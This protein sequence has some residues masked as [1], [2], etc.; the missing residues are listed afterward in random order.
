[1][2]IKDRIIELV[3]K[4]NTKE[5][6]Q[7]L[8]KIAPSHEFFDTTVSLSYRFGDIEKQ[9]IKGVVT[10]DDQ[11][12][13]GNKVV[14]SLTA[15][16]RTL[17]TP[18]EVLK[19]RLEIS[20]WSESID[21]QEV[22]SFLF[23]VLKPNHHFQVEI[24]LRSL[25]EHLDLSSNL[26]QAEENNRLVNNSVR[27]RLSAFIEVLMLDELVNDWQDSFWHYC[28]NNR[29]F[30]V[31]DKQKFD[32]NFEA[33]KYFADL[34][35][36]ENKQAIQ[37]LLLWQEEFLVGNYETSLKYIDNVRLNLNTDSSKAY[38]YLLLTHCNLKLDDAVKKYITKQDKSPLNRIFIYIERVQKF[39]D[40]SSTRRESLNFAYNKI[41][42]AIQKIYHNISFDYILNKST[43]GISKKRELIK[44]TI[45][46]SILFFGKIKNE[47]TEHHQIYEDLIIELI[48]GGKYTWLE[49]RYDKIENSSTFGAVERL[50]QLE[51]VLKQNDMSIVGLKD[52]LY[53]EL[54]VKAKNIDKAIDIKKATE[55]LTKSCYLAFKI[56]ND[57]KF[58]ELIKSFNKPTK[59]Q[60]F[61]PKAV[62]HKQ[63]V[64]I[65]NNQKQELVVDESY[66]EAIT[67][68]FDLNKNYDEIFMINIE[69]ITVHF[70]FFHQCFFYEK[71]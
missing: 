1:M 27:S 17:P 64:S 57:I 41:L 37:Q 25:D 68:V 39:G 29:M 50:N 60:G 62:I 48:G 58:K 16:I 46:L 5:A 4:G 15:H 3:A 44:E 71:S 63:E 12:I 23:Q 51:K 28:M 30:Y 22:I 45:A 33:S 56:F 70:K 6:I 7:A 13:H 55:R 10:F 38:E 32:E 42:S 11:T 34:I 54:V 35:K 69:S 59:I 40:E 67:D 61:K 26:V 9:K 52:Y 31:D 21:I 66:Q 18:I 65:Q 19:G 49:F 36:G 8:L 53:E 20:I 47:Y 2:F 43:R 14:E 24:I